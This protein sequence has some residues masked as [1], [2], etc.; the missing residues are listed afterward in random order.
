MIYFRASTGINGRPR[1][2]SRW[3]E[4]QSAGRHA[5]ARGHEDRTVAGYLID[6]RASDLPDRFGD[7]VHAVD[8]GLAELTAVRVERQP[9]AHLDR[10]IGDEMPCLPART[11]AKFLELHEYVR[12]EVVVQ[13]RRPDLAWPGP[14][15]LP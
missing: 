13:D 3:T 5:G 11:Q 8:V 15:V 14:T 4:D 6:R 10:A 9:S 2:R 7:P 12:R 1:S